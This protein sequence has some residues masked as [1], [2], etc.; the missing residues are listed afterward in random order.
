MKKQDK[1]YFGIGLSI[2][3]LLLVL[4]FNMQIFMQVIQPNIKICVEKGL[5]SNVWCGVENYDR[6][7]DFG[8]W[9]GVCGNIKDCKALGKE[10]PEVPCYELENYKGGDKN[11][12]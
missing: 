7:E 2:I 1:I 11:D 9:G 4:L 8:W 3:I 6:C 5:N 12:T 10:F